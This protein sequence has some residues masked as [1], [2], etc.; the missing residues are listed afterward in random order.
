MVSE[1]HGLQLVVQPLLDDYLE[2]RI[3]TFWWF[4][5]DCCM[6]CDILVFSRLGGGV[7]LDAKTH[8]PEANLWLERLRVYHEQHTRA[9][10]CRI[11]F[12]GNRR[13]PTLTP[14]E[15]RLIGVLI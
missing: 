2:Y 11:R 13:H 8:T 10:S 9:A 12:K 7:A 15:R 4:N 3:A 5:F 14:V 1:G 6:A